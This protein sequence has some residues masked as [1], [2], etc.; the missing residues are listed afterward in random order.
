MVHGEA[1]R[2]NSTDEYR[3]LNT[4]IHTIRCTE[5]QQITEIAIF[6]FIS[7][8]DSA[9]SNKSKR[10]LH[11]HHVK[12]SESESV[13][14][15]LSTH[16]SM[17][18]DHIYYDPVNNARFLDGENNPIEWDALWK[19]DIRCTGGYWAH[20]RGFNARQSVDMSEDG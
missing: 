15:T 20:L 2:V 13:N 10:W 6:V 19:M 14:P 17:R 16:S 9:G 5:T 8:P 4:G 11:E 3:V 12:F 1:R 7:D 18:D